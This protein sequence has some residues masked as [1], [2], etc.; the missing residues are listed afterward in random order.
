MGLETLA[1]NPEMIAAISRGLERTSPISLDNAD[2]LAPHGVEDGSVQ[3]FVNGQP[4]PTFPIKASYPGFVS[5]D[6]GTMTSPMSNVQCLL[7]AGRQ[8]T[9]D[10]C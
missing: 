6:A 2:L 4:Q 9:L 10:I 8:W 3:L 5:T 7:S 1:A